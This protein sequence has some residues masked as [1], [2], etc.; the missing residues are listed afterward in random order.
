MINGSKSGFRRIDNLE[1]QWGLKIN[2]G[3]RVFFPKKDIPGLRYSFRLLVKE[4]SNSGSLRSQLISLHREPVTV[5]KGIDV[6]Q[7]H[8]KCQMKRSA[9]L[10]MHNAKFILTTPYYIIRRYPQN[11]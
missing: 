4:D 7:T 5:L 1:N 9:E 10:K 6:S 8:L 3:A 11:S 2:E